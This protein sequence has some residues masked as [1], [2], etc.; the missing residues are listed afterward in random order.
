MKSEVRRLSVP[1][2]HNNFV[3]MA[4]ATAKAQRDLTAAKLAESIRQLK[5]YLESN[6]N[7]KRILGK[8]IEKL[9]SEKEELL[10]HHHNYAE[11]SKIPLEDGDM[12]QFLTS[13]MDAADDIIIETMDLMDT[14]SAADFAKDKECEITSA[15][16]KT[17]MEEEMLFFIKD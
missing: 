5:R 16:L 2:I 3:V 11:K 6:A 14:L 13:K 12:T 4:V 15:K 17:S 9:E 10:E 1:T 7:S 8:R